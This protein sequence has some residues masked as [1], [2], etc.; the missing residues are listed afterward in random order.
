MKKFT[1]STIAI[2]AAMMGLLS[3]AGCT[4]EET[5][6]PT[7][8]DSGS[9]E[10]LI[11]E[12]W[13]NGKLQHTRTYDDKNRL[14]TISM[15]ELD[16]AIA[17]S[18]Y[19]YNEKGLVS[20]VS[21]VTADGETWIDD[22]EYN[23]AGKLNKITTSAGGAVTT[24]QTFVYSDNKLVQ[25]SNYAEGGSIVQTHTFDNEGNL[26]VLITEGQLYSSKVEFGDFD[27]KKAFDP[28][29]VY[30]VHK[31]NPRYVKE[32]LSTGAV[33][34]TIHEYKYNEAGYIIED[35]II[36]KATNSL[37]GKMTYKLIKK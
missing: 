14:E 1:F 24:V 9:A 6:E 28:I 8:S 18:N 19:D 34:E 33:T 22:Y 4:K 35:H 36:D 11:S 12:A 23:S 26:I 32:T 10:Y 13:Y 25:T 29:F 15:F 5:T 31:H 17:T 37:N 27:D 20:Q 21:K 16:L 3:T 30:D 7:D 2:C